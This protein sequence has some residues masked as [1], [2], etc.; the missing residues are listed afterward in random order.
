MTG[1]D[2][3]MKLYHTGVQFKD[4]A[5]KLD[6][7][8]QNFSKSLKV[9]DI[10]TGFLEKLCDALGVKIDFFY[11]GTSYASSSINVTA[12]G[13]QAIATNSGAVKVGTQ[14]DAD[15]DNIGTQNNY[16]ADCSEKSTV[17]KTLT[18]SVSTLTRELE[19][20]QMQ[21]TSLINI[22]EGNQRQID[23]LVSMIGRASSK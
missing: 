10:K 20:S 22:I 1:E 19:T 8:Q 17:V 2:L 16:T 11:T 14:N 3:K 15:R 4:L 5:N 13:K 23:T 6:M 7:T 18:E 12:S 9:S 21:K